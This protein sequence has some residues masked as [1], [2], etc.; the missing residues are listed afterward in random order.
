MTPALASPYEEVVPGVAIFQY[1]NQS[2]WYVRV[3]KKESR[4]YVRK[5]LG[6]PDRK[7]ALNKVMNNL[8]DI[9]SI[10]L[11]KVNRGDS[12]TKVL[13]EFNE[14]QRDRCDNKLIAESS[15]YW[16]DRMSKYFIGWFAKNGYKYLESVQRHSLKSYCLDRM[17]EGLVV[18]SAN[19][20]VTYLR[21]FFNWCLDEGK[22]KTPI[23]IPKQK[24]G[25]DER[26]K[27]PPFR[28]DDLK[29][30]RKGIDEF[31]KATKGIRSVPLEEM[32]YTNQLFKLYMEVLLR[33]GARPH[34]ILALTWRDVRIGETESDRRRIV[35]VCE[36]PENTKRGSRKSIF[37]SEALAELKRLETKVFGKV[38][39]HWSIFRS[40]NNIQTIDQST[41]RRKWTAINKKLGFNYKLYSTRSYRITEMILSDIPLPLIGRNVGCSVKQL[42]DSYLRYAPEKEMR[43]LLKEKDDQELH[44]KYYEEDDEKDGVF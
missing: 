24:K 17:K 10:E 44:V 39:S 5:T 8:S 29:A 3:Y 42:S 27:N 20:E 13:I 7:D 2:N 43:T 23:N 28:P 19:Q 12:M 33:S 25:V 4:S 30:L 31:V 15:F 21:A 18:S 41:F 38:E 6:T 16:Y 11:K 32:K 1:A 22:I 36:I 37:R 35:N 9:F 40:F 34:E 26:L 14:Y